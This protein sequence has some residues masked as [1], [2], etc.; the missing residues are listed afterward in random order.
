MAQTRENVRDEALARLRSGTAL[1]AEGRLEQAAEDL[2]SAEAI[3]R[4]GAPRPS[5]S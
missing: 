3:F 1:L 4:P 2:V 5:G